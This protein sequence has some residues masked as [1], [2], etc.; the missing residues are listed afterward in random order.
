MKRGE[1]KDALEQVL[2]LKGELDR[3][4][5]PEPLHLVRAG[6]QARC[7]SPL[8]EHGQVSHI[9]EWSDRRNIGGVGVGWLWVVPVGLGCLQVEEGSRSRGLGLVDAALMRS[10]RSKDA[11]H[12]AHTVSRPTAPL[13]SHSCNYSCGR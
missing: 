9:E 6:E 10:R 12:Q 13:L 7:Q 3:A 4:I 1:G 11:K 2:V 5:L 8:V